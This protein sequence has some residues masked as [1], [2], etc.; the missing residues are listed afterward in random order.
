M[1]GKHDGNVGGNEFRTAA[2]LHRSADGGKLRRLRRL[3]GDVRVDGDDGVAPGL[4]RFGIAARGR[5]VRLE[6][7]VRDVESVG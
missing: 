1:D 6:L 7:A 4:D 5:D 3:Q 2:L